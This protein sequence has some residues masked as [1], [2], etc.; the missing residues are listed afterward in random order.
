MDKSAYNTERRGLDQV[1]DEIK[2]S[3]TSQ[4][5]SDVNPANKQWTNEKYC[6]QERK[7]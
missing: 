1:D 5:R 3:Q 4:K 7:K 6:T 2:I